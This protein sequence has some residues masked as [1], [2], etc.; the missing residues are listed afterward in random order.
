M[1]T[2]AQIKAINKYNANNTVSVLL[3]LNKKTDADIIAKLETVESKLGYVKECI[4][5]DIKNE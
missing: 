4:R 2:K 5:K 3:R 1:S